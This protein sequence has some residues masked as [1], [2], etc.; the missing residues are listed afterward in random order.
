VASSN[1]YGLSEGF[2]FY[3]LEVENWRNGHHRKSHRSTSGK[4]KEKDGQANSSTKSFSMQDSM[5]TTAQSQPIERQQSDMSVSKELSN[6]R[7]YTLP[8][9]N[10]QDSGL[11]TIVDDAIN[12][13]VSSP[14]ISTRRLS[15]D[16][17]PGVS[18]TVFR[19]PAL[20]SNNSKQSYLPL[21]SSTTAMSLSTSLPVAAETHSSPINAEH[22]AEKSI[23]ASSAVDQS[24]LI[25]AA[26]E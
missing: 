18:S 17:Q 22:S 23:S 15:F 24:S 25:W 14:A 11:A 8:F 4:D 9:I 10:G 1:P 7:R 20:P 26:Q 13:S 5:S 3:Q 2:K 12:S 6:G 16:R 21:T 19:R